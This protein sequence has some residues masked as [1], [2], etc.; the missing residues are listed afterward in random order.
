MIR[1]TLSSISI[2]GQ[3]RIAWDEPDI[4]NDISK[5][6]DYR[7]EYIMAKRSVLNTKNIIS[8]IH[9]ELQHIVLPTLGD[10]HA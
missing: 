7:D 2:T 9:D 5:T 10:Y 6:T 3:T 4:N 8:S 1:D